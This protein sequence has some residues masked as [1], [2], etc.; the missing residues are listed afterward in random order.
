[1][2]AIIIAGV[3]GLSVAIW[4]FLRLPAIPSPIDYPETKFGNY[5]AIKHAIW[6]DDFE[7]V[8]KFSEHLKDSDIQSVKMDV[9][10]G[11]FLAGYFDDSA[12]ILAGEK[13]LPA[14]AAYIAYL[15]QHDDWKGIHKIVANDNSGLVAPLRIWASVAVGKE[16]EALK[17][18]DSLN[19][20][21]DWKLFAKGMVYA[22]TKRPEKAKEFF[23][24]VPLDFLNLNDYL[25]LLAFYEEHGFVE[26]ADKLYTDFSATPGGSFVDSR[27][28]SFDDYRGV[29]NAL[30][31]GLLQNISHTPAL[32]YSSAAL[33]LLRLAQA[34][35]EKSDA[36]NYYLGMFF[37]NS[38]SP[39]YKEY[40]EKIGIESPFYPFILLK[41]AEKAGNF[42]KMR[43]GLNAVLKK[44][45][46]FMPALNKLVAINLQKDRGN[47]AL[48]VINKALGQPELSDKTQAYLLRLRA[49]SHLQQGNLK[50]AEDDILKA[51]D[52]TPQNPDVLLDT[53]KIW[54]AKKE[55]LDQAYFYAA[56]VIKGSPSDINGWDT[57]AMIVWEKEGAEEAAE[58]LERVGR[59]A[60]DNSALFQHLGDV[61]AK[62]GNRRGAIDAYERA[63]QLSDDGLSCGE[64]CLKKKIKRLK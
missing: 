45:P 51:G 38:D 47:D 56:S 34:A 30:G 16:S 50:R 58:I 2:G 14:R 26:D 23:D 13:P 25:Y 8:M 7:S 39:K 10:V 12:K 29:K 9:A 36:L 41:K 49:R 40:F 57:L 33:V 5:L 11:R 46:V 53:A 35:N 44:N 62:L 60:V 20:P 3:L 43:A 63:L 19:S 1:M 52:L 4:D 54:A 64:K 6:A 22:E 61:R 48:R 32:S 59:V 21:E 31:F 17:F 55:N 18:I 24:K 15:L 28:G 37:Y 27:I 42:D